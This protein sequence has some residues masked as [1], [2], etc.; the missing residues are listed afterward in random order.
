MR[1]HEILVLLLVL[2]LGYVLR[3][4]FPGLAQKVGLPG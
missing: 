4:F 1:A 2:V 3:G